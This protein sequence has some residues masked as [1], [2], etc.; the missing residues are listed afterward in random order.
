M[1]CKI[2]TGT[3][4]PFVCCRMVAEER[5]VVEQLRQEMRV[6]ERR[7]QKGNESAKVMKVIF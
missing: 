4:F 1:D 2:V 3:R 5:A 6:M 7:Y